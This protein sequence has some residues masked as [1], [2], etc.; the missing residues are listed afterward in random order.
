MPRYEITLL[1]RG[2]RRAAACLF[3]AVSA[4]AF[5]CATAGPAV[6]DSTPSRV[7]LPD[8][9][10]AS[11]DGATTVPADPQFTLSLRV[12]LSGRSP[13]GRVQ[14]ALAVSDPSSP[15]YAHYL[16]PAQYVATFGPSAA[17]VSTVSS[18]LRSQG[19]TITAS[20]QHYLAVTATVA[21]ADTAFD[22]AISEF[23]F[24][25]APFTYFGIAPL[26]GASVPAALGGDIAT[27]TGLET[28]NVNTASAARQQPKSTTAPAPASHSAAAADPTTIPCSQYW[29]QYSAPIPQ[30]FGHT[31]APTQACGYTASQLRSAYGITSSRYIGKGA[32]IAIILDGGLSTME[33]DANTYFAGQ[34]IP[35]FAPGQYSENVDSTFASTCA[36]NADLPEEPLDVETAHIAAPDAKVVYVGADCLEGD[37]DAQQ[38]AFLDAETRVVD[39][40]LADVTTD[41]WSIDESVFSAASTAAWD[42]IFQQGALEG[43]GFNFDAGDGGDGDGTT[44]VLF[45]ASDAWA[46]AAGGTTL[47]I[48][49]QGTPVAEYGWGDNDDQITDAGYDS[50]PPGP[51]EEGTTGGPSTLFTEPAYQRGV[52][53]DALATN[54]TGS[55]RRV[56]PDVA[57]DAGGVWQIGFT[58]ADTDGVYGEMANGGTSGA[59]PMIAGLEADAKQAAGHAL[60]FLNPAL[61]RLSGTS[62]IHDVLPINPA[63]PPIEVGPFAPGYD[64]YGTYL[65]TMGEDSSLTVTSGFDDVTGV[66]SPT[67]SFVTA[68]SRF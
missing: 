4:T 29:Q 54:G 19:M 13:A 43:I 21:E 33:S 52:V 32:T 50:P 41:S 59:S 55:A 53:P 15:A 42:M 20:T 48:G 67:S 7:A 62:A 45:P 25:T 64:Q 30:A 5:A 2:W 44:S 40:H 8:P 68:F 35:G 34:G 9:T 27:V 10:P 11:Y 56:V 58:G 22:T 61:Y 46:T 14:A 28:A 60:G 63:D 49:K 16:T 51:F 57:A 38:Q 3:A 36:G 6:A 39:A 66:G 31:T 47:E 18:W 37:T 12:Y 17:Q 24:G 26:G 1:A 23:T 65:T